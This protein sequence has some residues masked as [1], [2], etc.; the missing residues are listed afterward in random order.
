MYLEKFINEEDEDNFDKGYSIKEQFGV[1]DEEAEVKENQDENKDDS[2]KDDDDSQSKF[3]GF[4][5][6]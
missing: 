1:F 5:K 2:N 4:F 6:K 3:K